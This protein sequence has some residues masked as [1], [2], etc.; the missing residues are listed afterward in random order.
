MDSAVRVFFFVAKNKSEFYIT[1]EWP[2]SIRRER[3]TKSQDAILDDERS[4]SPEGRGPGWP[5]SERV[6]RWL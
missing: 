6:E 5:E 2:P 1:P 4:E 3:S